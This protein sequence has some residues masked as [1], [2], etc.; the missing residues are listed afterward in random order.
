M[1]NKIANHRCRYQSRECQDVWDGI[2][3]FVDWDGKARKEARFLGGKRAPRSR[4]SAN[5][6]LPGSSK[7][8]IISDLPDFCSSYRLCS[9]LRE[10]L[11]SQVGHGNSLL[12]VLQWFI[13]V[14][15]AN[16]SPL[17][18]LHRGFPCPLVIWE[19]WQR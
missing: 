4:I 19:S 6:Y 1:E 5:A 13:I 18:E 16:P 14:F 3:I 17:G 12:I 2:D 11:D 9:K 15:T 8:E 7:V 10:T